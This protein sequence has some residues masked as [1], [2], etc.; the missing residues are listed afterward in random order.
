[1]R[2]PGIRRRQ[3]RER[4]VALEQVLIV[5]E[6]GRGRR[7]DGD[8]RAHRAIAHGTIPREIADALLQPPLDHRAVAEHVAHVG[9]AEQTHAVL[10]AAPRGELERVGRHRQPRL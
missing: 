6:R 3:R 7:R 4:I 8:A 5:V 1:V 2:E 10:R 9:H